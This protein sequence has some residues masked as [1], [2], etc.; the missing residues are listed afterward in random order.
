[1]DPSETNSC[2]SSM[3][4]R[5]PTFPLLTPLPPVSRLAEDVF[6]NHRKESKAR[7][8]KL[9]LV[10]DKSAKRDMYCCTPI[11]LIS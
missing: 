6:I 5:A 10:F 4:P 2:L 11:E 9:H 8:W 3:R 7:S 1:M